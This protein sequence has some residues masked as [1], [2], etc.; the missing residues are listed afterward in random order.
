MFFSLL[1]QTHLH[2]CFICLFI[3]FGESIRCLKIAGVSFVSKTFSVFYD[4][5][6]LYM[7]VRCRTLPVL[8]RRPSKLPAEGRQGKKNGRRKKVDRSALFS[9]TRLFIFE[10]NLLLSTVHFFDR[11]SQ[12]RKFIEVNFFIFLSLLVRCWYNN[13]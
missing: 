7:G 9:N 2:L 13:V 12:L 8:P 3:C 11:S 5:F 10:N 6:P 4:S 1:S